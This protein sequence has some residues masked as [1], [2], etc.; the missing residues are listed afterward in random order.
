MLANLLNNWIGNKKC[1]RCTI[2]A[3]GAY[4]R[5]L[6]ST[7]KYMDECIKCLIRFQCR[8]NQNRPPAL[9]GKR[10]VKF[11]FRIHIDSGQINQFPFSNEFFLISFIYKRRLITNIWFSTQLIRH[12]TLISASCALSGASHKSISKRT[13]CMLA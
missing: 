4:S 8:E 2:T 6:H 12:V 13:K 5:I 9:R 3:Q 7:L 1:L 10:S 11:R